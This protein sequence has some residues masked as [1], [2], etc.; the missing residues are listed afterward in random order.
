MLWRHHTW[1]AFFY[2]AINFVFSSVNA[3]VNPPPPQFFFLLR[4]DYLLCLL[5]SEVQKKTPCG[6]N[7]II[8]RRTKKKKKKKKKKRNNESP[9]F[10]IGLVFLDDNLEATV[11]RERIIAMF[12]F[13]SFYLFILF[14]FL[15]GGFFDLSHWPV[16]TNRRFLGQQWIL[17]SASVSVKFVCS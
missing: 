6:C 3:K 5:R 17:M 7:Y 15:G 14:F 9:F 13:A 16:Y 10:W 11:R 1:Y 4:R 8:F 12:C 2:P